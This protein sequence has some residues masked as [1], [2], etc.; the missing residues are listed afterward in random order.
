M[1]D[2]DGVSGVPEILDN[3]ELRVGVG[4]WWLEKQ[5]SGECADILFAVRLPSFPVGLLRSPVGLASL[6]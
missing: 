5:S 2:A 4:D 6:D 1:Q 3:I